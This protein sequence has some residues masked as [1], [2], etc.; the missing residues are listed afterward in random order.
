M[1]LGG[2]HANRGATG[3][4]AD[5]IGMSAACAG[6]A[7]SAACARFA[8]SAASAAIPLLAVCAPVADF[9]APE[10]DSGSV[11]TVADP[12][13]GERLY[14]RCLACHALSYD[15]V[16]PRDCRCVRPPRRQRAGL[17]L[18]G[19][20]E[21]LEAALGRRHARPLS[22]R[23]GRRGAGQHHTYAGVPDARD[24]ADLIAICGRRTARL[25]A[26]RRRRAERVPSAERA[27]RL[28]PAT[29][30]TSPRRRHKEQRPRRMPRPLRL[31][32]GP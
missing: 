31:T 24:R 15:R 17:R 18:F 22:R 14:V 1:P 20:D 4:G 29:R 6:F 23:A 2:G 12:L 27:R 5:E 7:A 10:V 11:K 21:G 8:A 28:R 16:G 30:C 13:R 26:L 25:L 19:G 3:G 32:G 9:A